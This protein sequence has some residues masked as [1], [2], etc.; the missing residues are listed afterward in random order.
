VALDIRRRLRR[1]HRP[2][3]GGDLRANAHATRLTGAPTPPIAVETSA[4][5]RE[6]TPYGRLCLPSNRFELSVPPVF[7]KTCPAIYSVAPVGL[8][9]RSEV[10]G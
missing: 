1:V 6:R 4:V 3:R 8:I 2:L 9:E 7:R 5:A 10:G